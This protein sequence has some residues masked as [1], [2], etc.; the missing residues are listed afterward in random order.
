ML[1]NYTEAKINGNVG[2]FLK[3]RTFLVD[4]KMKIFAIP[5]IFSGHPVLFFIYRWLKNALCGKISVALRLKMPLFSSGEN[6]LFLQLLM[7]FIFYFEACEKNAQK[8]K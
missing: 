6:S 7:H 4:T 2:V 8:K 3:L 1:T 5:D